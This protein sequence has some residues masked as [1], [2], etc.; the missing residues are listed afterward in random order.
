MPKYVSS[1]TRYRFSNYLCAWS[2]VALYFV[3]L[4]LQN[5]NK[6]MSLRFWGSADVQRKTLAV[7]RMLSEMSS[8]YC[9]N[10]KMQLFS[11]FI[12]NI[13][14]NSFPHY[15]FPVSLVMF[16]WL[17]KKIWLLVFFIFCQI[18]WLPSEKVQTRFWHPG[19]P[20]GSPK[21]KYS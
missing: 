21:R 6:T 8:T 2:L 15:W 9:S 5:L 16:I 4:L 20:A 10:S 12:L 17:L 18:T 1:S 19:N 14:L 3:L 7:S 11:S 13:F